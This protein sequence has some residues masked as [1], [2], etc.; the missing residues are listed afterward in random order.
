MLLFSMICQF[1]WCLIRN[2]KSLG[3]R[4]NVY[5][6]KWCK[7]KVWLFLSLNNFY[8]QLFWETEA[9]LVW[10]SWDQWVAIFRQLLFAFQVSKDT[11]QSVMRLLMGSIL[12]LHRTLSEVLHYQ[13]V[14]KCGSLFTIIH[15]LCNKFAIKVSLY[16]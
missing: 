4:M 12:G 9:V 2:Q 11:F 6:K 7:V 14:P 13:K 8:I 5:G 16:S 1:R 3:L 15:K 10:K